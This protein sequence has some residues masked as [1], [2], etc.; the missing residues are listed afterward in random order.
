L[1]AG[2]A[3]AC[4]T[5]LGVGRRQRRPRRTVDPQFSRAAGTRRLRAVS[6][7][8][9]EGLDE[10]LTVTRLRPAKGTSPRAR[11]PQHRGESPVSTASRLSQRQ[12]RMARSAPL[13]GPAGPTAA[14][15]EAQM[16]CRRLKAATRTFQATPCRT[17]HAHSHE[18]PNF[19]AVLL[20]KLQRSVKRQPSNGQFAMSTKEGTSPCGTW[21]TISS[22][23]VAGRVLRN[24]IGPSAGGILTGE[25]LRSKRVIYANPFALRPCMES[26]VLHPGFGLIQPRY[27]LLPSTDA[28]HTAQNCRCGNKVPPARRF[29][30]DLSPT[31]ILPT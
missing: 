7:S 26:L 21:E 20:V 31:M 14:M 15:Q 13:D 30:Q 19:T 27:A 1:H 16:A 5:I 23:L 9:L 28:V 2:F 12:K 24:K 25:T 11:M 3:R 8:I 17:L 4:A 6:A 10:I 22:F 29:I 18:S